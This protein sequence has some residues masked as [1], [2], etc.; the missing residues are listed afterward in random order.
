[1]TTASSSRTWSS[2]RAKRTSGS[3]RASAT[4]WTGTKTSSL[5]RTSRGAMAE[6]RRDAPQAHPLVDAS[7]DDMWRVSPFADRASGDDYWPPAGRR[8]SPRGALTARAE[9]AAPQGAERESFAAFLDG[10][11]ARFL[12]AERP[13]LEAWLRD[14]L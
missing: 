13:L 7:W 4:S 8:H 1:M 11:L 10:F 6:H 14:G 2:S 12:D 9:F 3:R 5:S